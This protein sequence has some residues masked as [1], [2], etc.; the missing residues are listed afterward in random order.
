MTIIII[1]IEG[2]KRRFYK[3]SKLSP[4]DGGPHVFAKHPFSSPPLYSLMDLAI[5]SDI[6]VYVHND[7][8]RGKN[9]VVPF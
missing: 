7:I 6:D 4:P 9:G 1:I 2:N 8:F 5:C 3:F